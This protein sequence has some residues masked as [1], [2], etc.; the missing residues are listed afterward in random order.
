MF[1]IHK[2]KYETNHLITGKGF[3]QNVHMLI[4][5]LCVDFQTV[6][7]RNESIGTCDHWGELQFFYS[8]CVLGND[9]RSRYNGKICIWRRSRDIIFRGGKNN[10]REMKFGPLSR[11]NLYCRGEKSHANCVIE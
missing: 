2:V 3:V 10:N 7:K 5:T 11:S 1:E 4:C 9:A 8:S 6:Y